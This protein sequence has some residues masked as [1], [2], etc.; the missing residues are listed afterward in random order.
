MRTFLAIPLPDEVKAQLTAAVQRLAPL[1]HEV[2]WC[3]K[4]Q[5]HLTLAFLGEVSPAILPHL[6]E[7]ANRVC[8]ALPAFKCRAYGFGFFGTKR[9][10]KTLWAGIDLTPE[11]DALYERLWLELGKFGYKNREPDFRPHV[12]LG[13]CLESARNDAVVRA[14]DADEAFEFG[15]W[16]VTR[17]TLYESR[18][19]PRGATYHTLGSSPLAGA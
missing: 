6:T 17:V 11:L 9:N 16:R 1:A 15:E 3:T 13:R 8:A 18:L 12:T 5:F 19:T 7:A 2:K 14:M 10:P 4:D